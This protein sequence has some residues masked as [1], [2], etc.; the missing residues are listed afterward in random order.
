MEQI[1]CY[2]IVIIERLLWIISFIY[3]AEILS[4]PSSE[5]FVDVTKT[6]TL[7]LIPSYSVASFDLSIL[8]GSMYAHTVYNFYSLNYSIFGSTVVASLIGCHFTPGSNLHITAETTYPS[9]K[10]SCVTQNRYLPKFLLHFR[11]Q[12]DVYWGIFWKEDFKECFN[13]FFG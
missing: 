13:T 7:P 1:I 9:R 2:H 8:A 12:I 11:A 10:L 3:I 4:L 5:Y 6:L